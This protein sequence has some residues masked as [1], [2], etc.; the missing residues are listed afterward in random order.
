MANSAEVK[1]ILNAVDN[2][3]RV[4]SGVNDKIGNLEKVSRAAGDFVSGLGVNFSALANPAMAAGQG[5]KFVYDQ[6]VSSISEFAE[7]GKQVESVSRKLGISAQESSKLIQVSDDLEV[8]YSTLTQAL[9]AGLS[10]GIVPSISGLASL[11]KEYQK[12]EDPVQRAAFAQE[13]FGRAG[14]E[15]QK[16]LEVAPDQLLQMGKAVEKSGLLMTQQGVEAAKEYR[17]AL[18]EL[19]DSWAGIKMTVGGAVVPAVSEYLK[20]ENALIAALREGRI[21]LI[22]ADELSI[23]YATH[24]LDLNGVMAELDKTQKKAVGTFDLANQM[25]GTQTDKQ[26]ML[27]IVLNTS[28][29]AYQ[30]SV[31]IVRDQAKAY[32]AMTK[33]TQDQINALREAN[34]ID[35]SSVD[36]GLASAIDSEL[37]RIKISAAGGGAWDEAFNQVKKALADHKITEPEAVKMFENI[38]V[39]WHKT[40][41]AAGEENI[42]EASGTLATS[43]Q[44]TNE[45]AYRMLIKP[46]EDAIGLINGLQAT[47]HVQAVVDNLNDL[48]G[49]YN[50]SNPNKPTAPPSNKVNGQIVLTPQAKGGDTYANGAY[51]VGERGP[52]MFIP[53]QNGTII[54]NDQLAKGAKGTAGDVRNYVM[55]VY[56]NAQTSTVVRDFAIMRSMA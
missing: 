45:Q 49:Q 23:R 6:V 54:P 19:Q 4:V 35:F 34:K 37:Q 12:I 1:L 39:G 40:L 41:I 24:Q 5:V 26:K 21:D 42:W 25:V 53:R 52:E 7:Y 2:A 33:A 13:R 29:A 8:E 50:P 3:S 22:K 36:F 18:D 51:L 48:G 46:V 14:L 20:L 15:M 27:N 56:T 10:K 30:G 17:L 16:I 11:A 55:H 9:K 43:L 31:K 38:Q 28:I 44:I 32:Y 47:L